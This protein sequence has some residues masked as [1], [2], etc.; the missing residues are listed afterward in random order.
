MSGP[1]MFMGG[2]AWGAMSGPP[3]FMGGGAWGA[4]SGPPMFMGGGAWGAM[5]GPPMFMGGGAWGAI[6]GP[7]SSAIMYGERKAVGGA[8]VSLIARGLTQRSRFSG[9]PALSSV[10]D[11]RAPPKGCWPTTAPVGLSLT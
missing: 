4:M 2:G 9:L 6:S 3:M 5:S 7:P 10:P 1:P 8:N 11:R